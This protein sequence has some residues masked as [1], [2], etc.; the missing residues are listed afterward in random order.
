MT[1]RVEV[2]VT[3]AKLVELA[4]SKDKGMTTKIVRKKGNFK[5]TVDQD[6]NGV[7]SGSA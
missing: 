1:S 3:I 5:L 4:Y 2:K 6:G 7:L